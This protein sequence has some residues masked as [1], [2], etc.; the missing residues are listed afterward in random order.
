[1][2][3]KEIY[4]KWNNFINNPKYSIYFKSNIELWK[5]NFEKVKNYID[6]NNYLP[7]SRDKNQEN[8]FLSKWVSCQNKNYKK[9]AQ[10]MLNKNIYYTWNDFINNSK[11][12]IYFKS[13]IEL[14]QES[15]E[16][17]KNYIDINN[18]RPSGG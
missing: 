14:W 18:K 5:Y 11:Y 2:K 8:S 17:V 6:T 4:N 10:I 16:K 7:S 15:F 9:K 1:M 13:N 12:S 3:N